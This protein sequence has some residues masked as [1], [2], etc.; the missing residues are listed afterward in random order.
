VSF[1]GGVY[2]STCCQHFRLFNEATAQTSANPMA[3]VD[4]YY[5]STKIGSATGT[6]YYVKYQN[7]VNVTAAC[8]LASQSPLHVVRAYCDTTL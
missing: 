5:G 1:T 4:L 7:G 6:Y 3:F 2:G 8:S